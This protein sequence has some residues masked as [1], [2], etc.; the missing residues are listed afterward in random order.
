MLLFN[1][2]PE[3]KSANE[4]AIT[5]DIKG[6]HCSSC[7]INIDFELEDLEGV[8]EAKTHYAKQ[9][10]EVSFYPDKVT[11]EQMIAV[12]TKLGYEAIVV[13]KQE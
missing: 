2:K 4:T 13:T 3:L 1:R 12:I 11:H 9:K 7:A 5:F 6:M 10:S 8:T